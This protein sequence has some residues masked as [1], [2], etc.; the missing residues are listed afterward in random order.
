MFFKAFIRGILIA[1]KAQREKTQNFVRNNFIK[2]IYTNEK[3]NK[4]Q[5]MSKSGYMQRA[6]NELK[7]LD[8]NVS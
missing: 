5:V 6:Y 7:I 2:A 8:A 4:Q 1:F 3:L